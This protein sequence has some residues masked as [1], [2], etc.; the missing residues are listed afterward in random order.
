MCLAVSSL[1][2]WPERE[3]IWMDDDIISPGTIYD[4]VVREAFSMFCF[5]LCEDEDEDEAA[6]MTSGVQV[7]SRRKAVVFQPYRNSMHDLGRHYGVWS[8][9]LEK[10]V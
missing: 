4:A 6:G 9:E 7:N 2:D 5:L 1:R 10:L 3:K 8:F